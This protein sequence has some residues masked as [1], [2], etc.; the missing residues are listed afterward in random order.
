L[1]PKGQFGR[2]NFK[3][4]GFPFLKLR[5]LGFPLEVQGGKAWQ[6][7]RLKR[8]GGLEFLP[9]R[10]PLVKDTAKVWG[11]FHTV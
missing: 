7:L 11:L 6:E 9:K 8:K 4:M 3:G 5:K 10:R 1:G 2:G